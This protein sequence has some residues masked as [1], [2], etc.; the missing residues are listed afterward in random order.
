MYQYPYTR[1]GM[2]YVDLSSAK[3]QQVSRFINVQDMSRTALE[4]A[5]V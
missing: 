1:Y 4:Y 3:L 5:S 2:A